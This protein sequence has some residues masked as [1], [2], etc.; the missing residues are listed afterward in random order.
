MQLGEHEGALGALVAL[1]H[2]A[3]VAP[4]VVVQPRRRLQE[5]RYSQ[6]K[7]TGLFMIDHSFMKF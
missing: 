1:G 4:H 7:N 2:A 3:V 6:S 5:E